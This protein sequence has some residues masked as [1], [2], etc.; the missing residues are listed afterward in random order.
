MTDPSSSRREI[1]IGT[2]TDDGTVSAT[3]KDGENQ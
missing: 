3:C 1:T 2:C